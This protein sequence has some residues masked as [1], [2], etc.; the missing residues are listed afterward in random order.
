MTAKSNKENV[1]EQVTLS[2]GLA[3]QPEQGELCNLNN[4]ENPFYIE[5][6][7]NGDKLQIVRVYFPKKCTRAQIDKRLN[8][9]V[10]AAIERDMF[11]VVDNKI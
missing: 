8:M 2:A 7:G 11:E 6:K 3:Q 10:D 1:K 9:L 4:V 5:C